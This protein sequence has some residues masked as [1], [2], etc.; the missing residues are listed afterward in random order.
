MDYKRYLEILTSKP[1]PKDLAFS[2]AE[3]RCRV[4]KVKRLM[5][6]RGLD[7]LL[8]T[9]VSNI[10][11]LSG[12]DTFVPDIFACMVLTA[13]RDPILQIMEFEIPAALLYSWIKD[14]RPTKFNH[15]D[16]IARE[17]SGI[18]SERKLDGKRIGIEPGLVG[19]NVSINDSLRRACPSASFV[20]SS[21]LV[22]G[23]RLIKSPAELSY[24][25]KAADVVR[26]S[27]AVTLQAVQPGA[28]ENDI[29][30]VAYATLVKEG[31]E[32]FSSQPMV[33]GADRTGWIHVS[34][35]GKRIQAGDTV[36]MELGAFIRRYLGAVM[37]TAVIG[38]PSP[39]VRKLVKA[40]HD[41]LDRVR[42]LVKPGITAHAVAIE[43]KKALE[44]VAE[45]AYSTGM[46]GYSVGLS[47]PPNWQE[48]TF[49]I[50]EGRHEPMR[51]GMTF[52]T[53]ITL[54]I[55][56]TRGIG[57]TD[58][59]TVTETGCDILTARDRSLTVVPA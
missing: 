15:A 19:L 37:H 34:Q 26:K 23:I 54:R 47:V 57:F 16:Q 31:S 40:S 33:A 36:M 14:L 10:C 35:R 25:R 59:F 32:F 55:P 38:E 12:F 56:G 39:Q 9:D 4:E 24:M 48:G 6:E 51:P 41:T 27:L 42:E 43:A 11:Y 28:S 44:P 20:D 52:L 49:M 29:A 2:E 21:D 22:L 50:A 58:I 45:E 30:S 1:I 8:V 46:Y 18:L 53:P 17:I 5:S 13:D 7:A 3:Y